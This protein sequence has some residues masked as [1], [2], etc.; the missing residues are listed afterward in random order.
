MNLVDPGIVDARS[1]GQD[2]ILLPGNFRVF[3]TVWAGPGLAKLGGMEFMHMQSSK[4]GESP[5]AWATGALLQVIF[6]LALAALWG[7]ALARTV[8]S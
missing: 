3:G 8:P 1:H 6:L 2:R 4:V 5:W 7:A